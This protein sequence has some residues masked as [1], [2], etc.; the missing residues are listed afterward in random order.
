MEN[1]TG[2]IQKVIFKSD[3]T[4]Y[5]VVSIK[6]DYS[7]PE[8]RKYQDYLFTNILTVTCY[9][10]RIPVKDE[11]YS[12]SGE[13]VQTKYGVQLKA[14]SYERPNSDTLEA[15]VT[16]LS[17][18]Y[19]KG[20]GKI[21]ATRIYETLGSK[22][23]D[24]IRNDKSVLN[25][26]EGLTTEQKDIIYSVLL[27]NQKQEKAI[28]DLVRLGFTIAMAKKIQ[29]ILK[30]KEIK[31]VI[32]NP[33]YLIDK[34]EGI[35]FLK[36][37]S[38]ALHNGISKND[39]IRLQA[40]LVFLINN[41]TY[42]TG[43]CYIEKDYLK[44]RVLETL[45]KTE[46][47]IDTQT[48]ENILDD[49]VN[50]GKIVI[51]ENNLVYDLA[52]HH[53]EEQLAVNIVSRIKNETINAFTDKEILDALE[54]TKNDNKIIYSPMQEKA[55]ITALKENIMIIT[56]GPGT[57]K[58]TI[59]KGIIDTYSRLF[60]SDNVLDEVALLAPTGRA[61]KRLNEVT[62]HK[63]QTI[64]KFLGFDGKKFAFN[65]KNQVFAR[66]IIIDEMSMVDILLAYKLFSA[67]PSDCKIVI[68]G[69]V[70]Q[71]PS[72]SPGEVLSD[73]IRTKE[74]TTIYLNEIHR[75]AK[76]STIISLAHSVNQGLIPENIL[77]KQHDRNFIYLEESKIL[78][79]IKVIILQALNKNMDILKDIQVLIPMYRG[80][81]GIDNVNN[82][83][84]DCF[85]PLKDGEDELITAKQ[86]FRLNDK[87]IQLI[88]RNEDQIM[89]GDIGY[90]SSF[91]Y[92]NGQITGMTVQFE[93]N[94]VE[95][96]KEEY[97][98]LKLAYAI[99]IHKSQGSE[100]K[101]VI[102]P[103]TNKYYSMLKRKLYY[104]AIT[105]AKSFLIMIGNLESLKIASQSI[106]IRRKTK[107]T[108]IIKEKIGKKDI[109]PYDFL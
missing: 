31:I 30:P 38:I 45:N 41:Y 13:F 26:V 7:N 95:Y 75:Q 2:I 9:Y 94:R 16:Y 57:G 18:E 34:V 96:I 20:I 102:I 68:V 12:Y 73:I 29:S 80:E 101:T 8:M 32:K 10:D 54:K 65:E 83:L 82:F 92:I 105:R 77:E 43:N 21:T 27:E 66:M 55:I 35:G 14:N 60:N 70:D 100:F 25:I 33:Y 49:L 79:N 103:F 19:F 42:E 71:I 37:D 109:S 108:E 44:E 81:L 88:N 28:V 24:E 69:D 76:D 107:L 62:H 47:I 40:C 93:T 39:P 104:T 51:D 90:V 74:I 15:V 1:I 11:E 86:R 36:A 98:Q 17:S 46:E 22:C 72:V 99:S 84:Q 4:G 3:D 78:E 52:I 64:H 53:A 87:V 58:T 48:F 56:G 50:D 63:A 97:D 23:L 67:I 85:N 106:G 59:V 91:V 89:N 6:I 5:A 61:S